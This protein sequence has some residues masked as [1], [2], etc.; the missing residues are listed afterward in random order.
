M[1]LLSCV[2]VCVNEW[3]LR[4]VS[5]VDNYTQPYHFDDAFC[6]VPRPRKAL[7]C[8]LSLSMRCGVRHVLTRVC[9]CSVA[10]IFA[11]D[12]FTATNGATLIFPRSHLWAEGALGLVLCD[13]L[14]VV[15]HL[16]FSRTRTQCARVAGR[17]P[18]PDDHPIPCVMPAGS[19]VVFLSTLWHGGGPNT[20]QQSRLAVTFQ[21]CEPFIR[22]QENQF[23]VVP[24]EMLPQLS[25]K[26]VSMLGYSIH[27]PF[28][29]HV[30]GKH[31]LKALRA[32]L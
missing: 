6:L 1:S 4:C 29:G 27:P 26:M 13:L 20:S 11:I 9:P 2:Y 12:D 7:R 24:Q 31:P 19:V 28:I 32:K 10:S 30:D 15:T 21:Y 17:V 5:H 3:W 23:L 22:P 16:L 25:P 14:F 18:G 8:A